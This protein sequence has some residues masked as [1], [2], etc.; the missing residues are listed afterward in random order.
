[1]L[2]NYP[3]LLSVLTSTSYFEMYLL[4]SIFNVHVTT[5]VNPQ[6]EKKPVFCWYDCRSFQRRMKRCVLPFTLPLNG[7][8]IPR[9][10]SDGTSS[11]RLLQLNQPSIP[12]LKYVLKSSKRLCIFLSV[13]FIA[14]CNQWRVTRTLLCVGWPVWVTERIDGR[15]YV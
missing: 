9:T 5:E 15:I 1:M 2:S 6:R 14:T 10:A 3:R 7:L 4:Q 12:K 11:H 8:G 13:S